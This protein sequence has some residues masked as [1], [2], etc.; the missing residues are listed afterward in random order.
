[1]KAE[2]SRSTL[3]PSTL[4]VCL[5]DASL[6]SIRKA[7]VFAQD[8]DDKTAVGKRACINAM[9]SS[10]REPLQRRPVF[11]Q[12]ASAL[13]A[14]GLGRL[15]TG[16][17]TGRLRSRCGGD[18]LGSICGGGWGGVKGLVPAG[19]GEGEELVLCLTV[20]AIVQAAR[21]LT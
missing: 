13:R 14:D 10:R 2:L 5:F 15:T 8:S 3:V 7:L 11:D 12:D 21:D 4:P 20:A 1:M 9:P 6:N 19:T 16:W 17:M 18:S